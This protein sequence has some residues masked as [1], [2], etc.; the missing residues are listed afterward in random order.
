MQSACGKKRC[1]VENVERG[2]RGLEPQK[3]KG[4]LS[5]IENE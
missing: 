5:K 3:R 1:K 2:S 4:A